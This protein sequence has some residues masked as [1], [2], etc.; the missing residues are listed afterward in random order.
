M[1][2]QSPNK[3]QTNIFPKERQYV[4]NMDPSSNSPKVSTAPQKLGFLEPGKRTPKT[5]KTEGRLFE[6]RRQAL[7]PSWLVHYR[8][9]TA[10]RHQFL[11]LLMVL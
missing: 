7:A 8:W 6:L 9:K 10:T 11:T 4:S 1:G 5:T 2:Y 3:F